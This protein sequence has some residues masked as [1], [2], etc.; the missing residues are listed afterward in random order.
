MSLAP[1]T[2]IGS[3]EILDMIGVGGMGEVYRAQDTRRRR[4]VA[5]KSLP[6]LVAGD[7]DPLARIE[8]EAQT[9][10][11][12]NH[13]HIASVYG[14]EAS[15]PTQALVMELV[16]GP[17][18]ADRVAGGPLP[19]AEALTYARQIAD[20]LEAAH[21]R[22]I[23][24]RDLKPANI[25]L[26]A[27]GE[28][29][30]LDFGLAKALT[31]D[32]GHRAGEAANSPTLTNRA[33]Q[34]GMIL[35]TAAY[36][37]PEQARGKPVDRRADVWGFGCVLYELVT[38]RRAFEGDDITAVLARVIEREPNWDALPPATP[39]ALRRLLARCLIKEPKARL[40]DIG[41]ARIAID[42]ILS[43]RDAGTSSP[44]T[45]IPP[46]VLR[47]RPPTAWL[48]WTLAAVLGAVAIAAFAWPRGASAPVTDRRV[49]RVELSLP[50]DV[51][52]FSSPR[53]SRDATRVAFVGVRE[54][55]RQVY[56]RDL[57]QTDTRAI[58][59]TDGANMVAFAPSGDA[60]VV[61]GT[62]GRVRR[63]TLQ[64]GALDDLATGGDI[65]GGVE[66]GSDGTIYYGQI[67]RLMGIPS[68]GGAAREIVTLDKAG[69][70]TSV[71][72]PMPTTDGRTVL[73]TSWRDS[74]GTPR[75]RV[76]AVPAAGGT[77]RVVLENAQYAMATTPDRLVFQREGSLFV[78][79]FDQGRAE[80]TGAPIRI[81][82]QVH[83]NPNGGP[84]ADLA[85]TGAF[86]VASSRVFHGRLAWV[87]MD[88]IERVINAPA[89]G[90][91]NVRVSPD[92]KTVAFSELGAVWTLDL[93]RGAMT[94]VFGGL[95]GLTG[96][97]VWSADGTHLMFRT[98]DGVHIQR[99]DGEGQPRRIEGTT[100]LDY[101]SSA[102]PDG[103]TLLMLRI[104]S[105]SGGDILLQPIKG[106]DP[107]VAVRTKAYEGGPM[108]SPDGKWLA[109]VSN[110]SDRMEV[111]LRPVDGPDRKWPV[112][113][114]GGL[115]PLW[116]RD[117]KQVYFRSGQKM[118]VVDVQTSPDVRL[119]SP[120]TLFERRYS[121]GPNLTVPN[122]SLS[123]DGKDLLLVREES[124]SGHLSLVFNWLQNVGR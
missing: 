123:R 86:V 11:A 34:L 30:V 61:L 109:Y 35:G 25:K 56:V 99:A 51:E 17:T 96:F 76:E 107:R 9:L 83:I 40:R 24:H 6:A 98:A 84:A 115:H 48:P 12:L 38:G 94:R 45:P 112:S 63:L 72:W 19:V 18:L 111:Y 73:F 57:N 79:P 74:G 64:T 100:R 20:A 59:G 37:A 106:G 50:P 22:H 81:S 62:D 52:F 29:K 3:Y 53:V 71:I 70:E 46:M 78:V 49:T 67:T 89:R 80:V 58:A 68:G 95:N 114:G 110:E 87:S 54:G 65:L 7:A 102:S 122:Y 5:I 82:E 69:N 8:R 104:T 105:E 66:W 75:P 27:D 117:G 15:G 1:G 2:R 31:E 42:E 21:E 91:Q 124:G 92:G 113:S 28:V 14:L 85:G 120:R 103:L 77:R 93:T 10:A 36:M 101:P 23:I 55:T 4:H 16:E 47:E 108:V 118:Q 121:F 33:T 43:G 119:S 32:P 60:A 26:T 97:P 39:P 116:S 44:T 13:P 88:G 41:E 90:Y